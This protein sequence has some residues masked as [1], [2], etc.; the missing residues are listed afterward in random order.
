MSDHTATDAPPPAPAVGARLEPGVGRLVPERVQLSRAKGWRMPDRCL[1][2][3]RPGAWSN[4]YRVDVF[5]LDLALALFESTMAGYW[6]PAVVDGLSDELANAAYRL[7]CAA[8]AKMQRRDVRELRGFSLACWCSLDS[9]CH[10]DVLLRLAN[11][12]PPNV[13]VKLE[14]TA[15]HKA[16]ATVQVCI[17]CSAG[18]VACRWLSA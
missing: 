18:F 9:A 4:P 11:H 16:R 3:A 8:R 14:P 13:R 10:A 12:E 2:V 1:S 15:C 17:V 5:G 6:S 7:H